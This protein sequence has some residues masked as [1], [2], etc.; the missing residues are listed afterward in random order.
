MWSR[1]LI[2]ISIAHPSPNG[3][4]EAVLQ[5]WVVEAAKEPRCAHASSEMRPSS[6]SAGFLGRIYTRETA[7][8][9]CKNPSLLGRRSAVG[10]KQ[11]L[12]LE[13]PLNT[14]NFILRSGA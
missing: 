9:R 14:K 10:Q 6:D 2:K 4:R 1:L 8:R 12:R 5:E 3:S 11:T 7:C 13:Q